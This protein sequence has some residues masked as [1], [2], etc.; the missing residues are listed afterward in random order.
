[1]PEIHRSVRRFAEKKFREHGKL[2]YGPRS[3]GAIYILNQIIVASRITQRRDKNEQT[4]R[5]SGN[6]ENATFRIIRKKVTTF[7]EGFFQTAPGTL[8]L[9]C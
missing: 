7:G 3:S 6:F 5:G 1:M 8:A 4:N 2:L 9:T